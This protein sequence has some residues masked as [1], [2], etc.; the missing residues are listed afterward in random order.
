MTFLCSPM[1]HM[2]LDKTF[3][4]ERNYFQAEK[5]SSIPNNNTRHIIF[6]FILF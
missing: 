2:D 4:L 5:A 3:W 6:I 1:A